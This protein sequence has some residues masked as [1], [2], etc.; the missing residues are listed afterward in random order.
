MAVDFTRRA[1][2]GGAL[3]HI[4]SSIGQQHSL[5]NEDIEKR[6]FVRNVLKMHSKPGCVKNTTE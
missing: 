5:I 4:L 3:E 2:R 1:L 6:V